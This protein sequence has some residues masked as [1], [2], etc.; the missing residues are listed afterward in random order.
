[1]SFPPAMPAFR[2]SVS[3]I[4]QADRNI[5]FDRAPGSVGRPALHFFSL[6]FTLPLSPPALLSLEM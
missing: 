1:M 6:T 3:Q 5:I 2:I 4:R